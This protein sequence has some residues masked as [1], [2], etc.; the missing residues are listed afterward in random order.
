MD[1]SRRFVLALAIALAL[2]LIAAGPAAAREVRVSVATP[3]GPGPAEFNRVFVDKYGPKKAK[4]V[5]VLMPGTIAGSGN[6]T[7]AARHLVKS[8]KGLQ[9]WAI[10][11]RS[12]AIERPEVFQKALRGEATLQE[13]FDHYLGWITNGG[14]P[15]DH[16]NFVDGQGDF[17][18]ARQWG[19]GVALND[20]RAVVRQA[21]AKGKRKVVLGGHSLGASLTLAYAAWD[22]NGRPGYKDLSGLL[23]IDGGLLGSFDVLDTLPEA[24]D[25]I[26]QLAVSNPF[27]DL[28]GVGFPEITG[29]F[30]ELGAIFARRAPTSPAA[31][32][33]SFPLLPDA[34]NPPFAVTNRGLFGHAFDRDTS[35]SSLRLIHINGGSLAPSGDPRDW[36]DAGITPLN[37]LINSFAQEPANGVEWYF[38]RRLTIDTDGA[39]AMQRNPVADFLGLR[40]FHTRKIRLPLYALQ[41]NLTSGGVLNGARAFIKRA[42][43]TKRQSTLVDASAVQSHLDPLLAAPR[44]NRF[45]KTAVRF[46]NKKIFFKP[47]P[48]GKKRKGKGKR[49]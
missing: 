38:P 10:D 28:I 39:N 6:F 43:T 20:A 37:R 1:F 4:R 17:P 30:A 46:L 47:K 13:T 34:F 7:L 23:L 26:G 41:T 25:A 31:T 16:F 35:P 42:K 11:R 36:I 45:Y 29:I 49:G 2:G 9:V 48:K 24:Q 18:F 27:A 3:P 40:L 33:Q 12:Q 21:R 5:L 15:P 19:M 22:F 44:A 14:N 32:L 8:I